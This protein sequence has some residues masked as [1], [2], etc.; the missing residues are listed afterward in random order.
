MLIL[1]ETSAGYALFKIRK[2]KKLKEIDNIYTYLQDSEQASSLISLQAFDKFKDTGDAIKSAAKIVK[3]K[4]PKKLSK[5]LT[6]NIIS[7]E[8]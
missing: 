4:I 1:L 3:G 5:F 7:K 6:K 2:E 8:I